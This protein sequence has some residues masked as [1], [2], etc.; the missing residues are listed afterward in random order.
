MWNTLKV[1]KNSH[2]QTKF[3]VLMIAIY[4]VAMAWTTIQS[5]MRLVYSRSD[6]STPIIIKIPD[7]D[8]K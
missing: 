4:M 6:V 5:Y 1:F 7:P 2:R 8:Q 3:F